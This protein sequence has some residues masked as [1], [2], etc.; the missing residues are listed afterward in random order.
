MAKHYRKGSTPPTYAVKSEN[1]ELLITPEEIGRRWTEYSNHLLNVENDIEINEENQDRERNVE[2]EN[3][4]TVDQVQN[5]L[6]KMKNG[7]AS[8][9]DMIPP[10]ILKNIGEVI[11][12]IGDIFNQ[13]GN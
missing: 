11:L 3:P 5:V 10:E 12:W 8:G 7:K 13:C 9:E 2:Q 1:G 6:E 4:I